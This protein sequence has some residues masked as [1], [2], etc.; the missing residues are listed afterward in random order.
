ML[1]ERIVLEEVSARLASGPV[2]VICS[3]YGDYAVGDV[4]DFLKKA[5]IKVTGN[6][7]RWVFAVL[8]D[9]RDEE[10]IEGSFRHGGT[11]IIDHVW[12]DKPMAAH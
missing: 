1:E 11:R 2:G 9:K 10:K 3:P 5:G 12:F 8:K 7:N 4:I 6:T